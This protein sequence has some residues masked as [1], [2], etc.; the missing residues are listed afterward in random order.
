MASN[1]TPEAE[2]TTTNEQ[3]SLKDSS[4]LPRVIHDEFLTCKVCLEGFS[5]P[6]ILECLH[7]FCLSCLQSYCLKNSLNNELPCPMCR[8]TTDI[9]DGVDKLRDNFFIVSLQAAMVSERR[10]GAE[11]VPV[12]HP[13]DS[14]K[15]CRGETRPAEMRCRD[16][17]E[18][19]CS[20]CVSAHQRLSAT[21]DHLMEEILSAVSLVSLD[22]IKAVS[23][24]GKEQLEVRGIKRQED[25][26]VSVCRPS[27]ST[28]TNEDTTDARYDVGA[29]A[30]NEKENLI[31]SLA[32]VKSRMVAYHQILQ[33]WKAY[34]KDL[35]QQRMSMM[36]RLDQ[37]RHEI[38]TL[39]DGWHYAM[40][41]QLEASI[42]EE[43]MM[44]GAKI[45]LVEVQL[46]TSHAMCQLGQHIL[47]STSHPEWLQLRDH[48]TTDLSQ[49]HRENINAMCLTQRSSVAFSVGHQ[50]LTFDHFGSFT[51]NQEKVVSSA[52]VHPVQ[53]I[54]FVR[55]LHTR[56]ASSG[57]RYDASSI[58]AD[59]HSNVIVTDRQLNQIVI[60]SPMGRTLKEVNTTGIGKPICAAITQQG[61]L[62]CSRGKSSLCVFD[63]E[64]NH[65]RVISSRSF[66]KPCSVTV[67]HDNNIYALD[68]DRKMVFKFCGQTFKKT[69]QVKISYEKSCV[70]DKIA[71]NSYDHIIL[72]AHSE[73]CVY[74]YTAAGQKLA[75]YGR[76]GSRT[77]GELYWPRGMCVD[78]H[79]NIIIAD[80]Q[81]N[82][83]QLL[84]PQG[85]WTI[86]EATQ[87][88]M[89]SPTDV[90]VT[91]E[92]LLVVLEKNGNVLAF[93]Y[94]PF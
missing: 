29:V 35:D 14:C 77:A 56:P 55:F 4:T 21:K 59:T 81:N 45:E 80:T 93:E 91:S 19:L 90:A 41:Q 16:C 43:K 46:D 86:L 22:G 48:L 52:R 62:V 73:N 17:Q 39:V 74:E 78:A 31:K 75:Q 60:H 63:R 38:Q 18:L 66:R 65:T 11:R 5:Q 83:I 64:G 28:T 36:K 44:I 27:A 50:T 79:D 51:L 30:S 70:W 7:S 42:K 76:M 57:H 89:H 33:E 58:S 24:K 6:K 25:G 94:L 12:S 69:S 92:G 10:E 49:L 88:Q 3:E 1:F 26:S 85:S 54:H 32:F 9:K 2:G 68:E 34:Q 61:A 82:R 53:C 40:T 23:E 13:C 37:R 8:Q 15:A 84:S 71:I 20:E 47:D 67:S 72:C 87:Q